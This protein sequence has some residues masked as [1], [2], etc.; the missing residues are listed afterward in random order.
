MEIR[1][2]SPQFPA[3]NALSSYLRRRLRDHLAFGSERIREVEAHLSDVNGRRGGQDKRCR[4]IVRLNQAPEVVVE[5]TDSDLY[6][7]IR[8]SADR[9]SRAVRRSFGRR[10][11][12]LS[13]RVSLRG[14][15]MPE[16]GGT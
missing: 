13:R 4:L 11:D 2:E 10:L 14:Q 3:T 16:S 8:R 15:G 9:V 6:V 7:A 1:I 12:R 5:S